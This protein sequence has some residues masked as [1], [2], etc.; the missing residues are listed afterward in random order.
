MNK[1]DFLKHS[2][3]LGAGALIAPAVLA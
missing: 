1:R 2:L 3:V